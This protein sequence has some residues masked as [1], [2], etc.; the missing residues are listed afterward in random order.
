MQ[1]VSKL[2]NCNYYVLDR[3]LANCILTVKP[4]VNNYCSEDGSVICAAINNCFVAENKWR[5]CLTGIIRKI[6]KLLADLIA[7]S[8]SRKLTINSKYTGL[9]LLYILLI[10]CFC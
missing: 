7:F 3:P 1:C 10:S 6:H 8:P 2:L 9:F 5:G 4:L